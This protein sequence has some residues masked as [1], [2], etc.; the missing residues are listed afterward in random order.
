MTME[1]IDIGKAKTIAK[2]KGLLPGRVKGTDGVQFTKGRNERVE[3]IT[4]EEFE[5][6]LFKRG[7][8]IYESGGWMKLMRVLP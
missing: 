3:V 7:L 1:R 6:A 2:N 4:W 5:A 8:G